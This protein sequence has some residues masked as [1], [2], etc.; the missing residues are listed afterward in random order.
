[1]VH[2]MFALRQSDSLDR[3]EQVER[4]KM[5]SFKVRKSQGLPLSCNSSQLGTWAHK[6]YSNFDHI[7]GDNFNQRRAG[8]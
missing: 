1:M 4:S 2:E 7:G 3:F 8:G 6:F 5:L